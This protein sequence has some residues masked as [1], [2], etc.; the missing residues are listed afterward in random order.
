MKILML[1]QFY[2]PIL[3]G[4]ERHVHSLSEELVRR[5]HNVAVA[6]LRQPGIAQDEVSAGVHIYRL[7]GALQRA[8]FLYSDNERRHAP[9]FPDPETVLA[10]RRVVKEFKPDL[11]HAHNWMLY[12]YL[13]LK[14]WAGVPLVHTLHDYHLSCPIK[15]LMYYGKELCSG[16]APDKCPGC[17]RDHYGLTGAPTYYANRMMSR[18]ALEQVDRFLA[19]SQATA[20]GN[21]LLPGGEIECDIIPNFLPEP[22]AHGKNGR[23]AFAEAE[24]VFQLPGEGYLMFAGDLSRDKGVPVLLEAYAGMEASAPPLVLVGR[25]TPTTPESLPL[26]VHAFHS[27]PHAAVLEAWQRASIALAPST[28]SEPFGIVV[29]EAM[30][31][32]K[33]VIASKIGGLADIVVDG[34][35]GL[36]VEA[37]DA[38]ALRRAIE[39]LLGDEGLRQRM[40]EAGRLRVEQYRAGVVV[41]Q[42]EQ[43]YRDLLGKSPRGEMEGGRARYA[44]TK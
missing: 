26:N 30:A 22:P 5:G 36:L 10:L 11:V 44:R 20:E 16:P 1:A 6:T 2:P 12:A 40:G 43:V 24:R 17:S 38:L 41:A 34:E 39:C 32:G 7:P 42:I 4:E 13:P 37:G 3:G 23:P 9:P 31:A 21:G 29:I 33:P 35:T 15:R 8:S 18:R 28:W 27:W 25:R 14:N 19:V